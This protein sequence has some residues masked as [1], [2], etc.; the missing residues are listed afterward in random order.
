MSLPFFISESLL[1]TGQEFFENA[2]P[3]VPP[4]L[5]LWTI[6]MFVGPQRFVGPEFT[7][8][9]EKVAAA[10]ALP[11]VL[12]IGKQFACV[13]D[14]FDRSV[15][16]A[17]GCW[18]LIYDCGLVLYWYGVLTQAHGDVIHCQLPLFQLLRAF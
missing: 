5:T 8:L 6:E 14:L 13:F 18:P 12:L 7:A 17:V 10:V 4:G 2:L 9:C 11:E 15:Q 3:H 1:L 16:V